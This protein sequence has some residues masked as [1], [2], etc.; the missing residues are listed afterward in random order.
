MSSEPNVEPEYRSFLADK[1][2]KLADLMKLKPGQAG[3]VE[4]LKAYLEANAAA[5]RALLRRLDR[6]IDPDLR[7]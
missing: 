2:E 1:A 5:E 3:Y 7:A 4:S 6:R